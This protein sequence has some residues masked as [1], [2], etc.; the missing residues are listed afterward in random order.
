M[1]LRLIEECHNRI[2][3]KI[4]DDPLCPVAG[5]YEEEMTNIKERLNGSDRDQFMLLMPNLRGR[6]ISDLSQIKYIE[7]VVLNIFFTLA[8]GDGHIFPELQKHR[9][10]LIWSPGLIL[11]P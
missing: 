6:I 1:G 9:Q 11:M 8:D 3:E 2:K 4:R 10:K 7:F 5:I